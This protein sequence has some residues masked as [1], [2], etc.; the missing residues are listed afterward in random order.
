MG[1]RSSGLRSD[2]IDTIRVDT[3]LIGDHRGGSMAEEMGTFRVDIEIENTRT[4]ERREVRSVLVDTG[5]E[6]S[7]IPGLFSNHSASS[8]SRKRASGRPV[9]PL[10]SAGSALR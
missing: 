8:R 10:L 9:A 1:W 3:V 4:G 2:G 5:A 6:L 7:W